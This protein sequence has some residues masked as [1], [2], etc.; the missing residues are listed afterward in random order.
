[1]I[2]FDLFGVDQDRFV[3][4]TK[5]TTTQLIA[6]ISLLL[7]KK[8]I[9]EE[10]FNQYI[11]IAEKQVEESFQNKKLEQEKEFKENNPIM[12]KMFGIE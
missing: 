11:K 2:M 9:S 10:E 6:I 1:M 7:D 4:V 3:E 8:I 5:Y 12:A